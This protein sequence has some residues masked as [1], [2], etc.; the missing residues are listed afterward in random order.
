MEQ[1][2]ALML[3][4]KDN[5]ATSLQD[6]GPGSD[7]QVRVGKEVRHVTALERIPFGFKMA[8]ERIPKGGSVVKY[9]EPIGIA[10]RDIAP[11]QLVHVHNIEGARGRG[12][13][14][15]GGSQ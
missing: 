12:D 7:V 3:T 5:V 15:K 6:A 2:D 14:A 10:S 9:G 8:T 1:S 11:G 13:L 4:P